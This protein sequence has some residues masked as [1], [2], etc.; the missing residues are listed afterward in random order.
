M[1]NN[2]TMA[3]PEVGVAMLGH[4]KQEALR[5]LEAEI[6]RQQEAIKQLESDLKAFKADLENKSMRTREENR[7]LDDLMSGI[8]DLETTRTRLRVARLDAIKRIVDLPCLLNKLGS[9]SDRMVGE[10]KKMK[11]TTTALKS[12]TKM[13]SLANQ[14]INHIK[15]LA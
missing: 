9:I 13:E 5:S 14:T 12:V 8:G 4:E 2:T 10:A 15:G 1:V 7:Q 6:D 11:S 3:A